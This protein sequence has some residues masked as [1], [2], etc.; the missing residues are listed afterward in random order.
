MHDYSVANFREVIEMSRVSCVVNWQCIP[1]I[2]TENE[3]KKIWKSKKFFTQI[4]I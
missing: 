2:V 3:K 1:K 4:P